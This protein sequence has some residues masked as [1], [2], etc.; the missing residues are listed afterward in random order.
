MEDSE[1]RKQIYN[2][3][4]INNIPI[5]LFMNYVHDPYILESGTWKVEIIEYLKLI[6]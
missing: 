6:Y 5:N 1:I 2:L 4:S 3:R